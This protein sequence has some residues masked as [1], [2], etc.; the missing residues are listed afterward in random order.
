MVSEFLTSDWGRLCDG[1]ES[2]SFLFN[3]LLCANYSLVEKQELLFKPGL[4][5]DGYFDSKKL[6]DQVETAIDIFEGKTKGFAQGLF[7]F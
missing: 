7:I 2:V 5:R 1:D 6:I 3:G 4:N